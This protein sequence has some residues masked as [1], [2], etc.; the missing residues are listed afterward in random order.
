MLGESGRAT[1]P[2][3]ASRL[4]E[5][6][7][8]ATS[9]PSPP[10]S[11]RPRRWPRRTQRSVIVRACVVWEAGMSCWWCRLLPHVPLRGRRIRAGG[12]SRGYVERCSVGTAQVR[13][14]SGEN[15]CVRRI[16]RFTR[17]HSA[18]AARPTAPA[19]SVVAASR[20]FC[21]VHDI[22][23]AV[24][25]PAAVADVSSE[26]NTRLQCGSRRV[27]LHR[28]ALVVRSTEQVY[29]LYILYVR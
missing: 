7:E 23:W 24:V 25:D 11:R 27:G 5:R 9:P 1:P 14:R 26:A 29:V 16:G 13:T 8:C 3:M 17:E 2:T 6:P 22:L 15:T 28:A 18:S 12:K 4:E 10:P 19:P 21:A 20:V